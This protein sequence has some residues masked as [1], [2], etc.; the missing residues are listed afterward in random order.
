MTRFQR[1]CLA[2]GLVC[3]GVFVQSAAFAGDDVAVTLSAQRVTVSHGKEAF[4]PADHA[5]P[6]D[7][8]EYRATYRNT[9]ASDVKDLAATLPVP[10]GLSYL[11]RTANPVALLAST[12]G[13]SFEPVPL[14]RTVKLADGSTKTVEV[15]VSEYRYLR[16]SIGTLAAKNSRTV[17]A[18]MR[19]APLET[20]SA[21]P[22]R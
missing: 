4:M 9:G 21:V 11:P 1:R 13:R 5:R 10:A 19:V 2:L 16:W 14:K 18:R 12:D 22:A 20:V 8:I 17:R 15:S 7:V 3:L 6:G